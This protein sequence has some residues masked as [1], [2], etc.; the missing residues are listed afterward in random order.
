M[1][2]GKDG[3][4]APEISFQPTVVSVNTVTKSSIDDENAVE[5][6]ILFF[7]ETSGN[8]F[9]TSCECFD[10]SENSADKLT[11]GDMQNATNATANL[12]DYV[13]TFYVAAFSNINDGGVT[14]PAYR[15]VSYDSETWSLNPDD[16]TDNKLPQWDNRDEKV[17]FAYSAEAPNPYTLSCTSSACQTMSYIVPADLNDHKDILLGDYLGTTIPAGGQNPTGEVPLT[18]AHP[19]AAVT[20]KA[21]KI[22]GVTGINDIEISG[23]YASGTLTHTPGNTFSWLNDESNDTRVSGG[24]MPSSKL[25]DADL[26]FIP[27]TF[28]SAA[29]LA[30]KVTVSTTGGEDTYVGFINTGSWEA[31]K[32]YIYTL[33]DNMPLIEVTENKTVKNTGTFQCYV[34]ATVTGNWYVGNFIVA[35]W[36]GD[37]GESGNWRRGTDGYLY[38]QGAVDPGSQTDAISIDK[39]KYEK[40]DSA[41][42]GS[43]LKIRIHAQAGNEPFPNQ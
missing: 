26:L 19:L 33:G 11:K 29:P 17:F 15:Q 36:S 16:F 24:T 2:Q 8:N 7:S 5:E 1:L 22:D 3:F 18:F 42:E 20:F 34:R 27:Q 30:L 28:T 35:P 21:G 25:L 39:S 13:D 37:I 40:P 10:I 23:F 31:G 32:H 9:L 4:E 43:V 38:Y 12:R 14:I 41:P 6:K